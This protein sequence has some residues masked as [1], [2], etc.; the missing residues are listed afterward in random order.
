MI[1]RTI[2]KDKI[3]MGAVLVSYYFLFVLLFFGLNLAAALGIT[4][5]LI[6][7]WGLLIAIVDLIK[8]GVNYTS[9]ILFIIIR[10]VLG[11]KWIDIPSFLALIVGIELVAYYRYV[12]LERAVA[13]ADLALMV[14]YSYGLASPLAALTAGAI[15]HKLSEFYF[16]RQQSKGDTSGFPVAPFYHTA[17]FI[18]LV[19]NSLIVVGILQ[20][21]Y[22]SI[23][24]S[25][26]FRILVGY[27][28]Y[29]G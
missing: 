5:M 14:A 2:S 16:N 27:P 3:V 17:F 20:T 23:V 7:F 21:P 9:I 13:E 22:S 18:V 1:G 24:K 15:Y 12:Q 11:N 26:W 4:G 10:A 29:Y 19:V 6:F 8:K 25:I 28:G